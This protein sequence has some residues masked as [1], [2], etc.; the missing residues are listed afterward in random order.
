VR[1]DGSVKV[2][3]ELNDTGYPGC[4]YNLIFDTSLD[5]LTGTYF[6]AQM[7]ETWPVVFVRQQE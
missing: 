2:G 7:R 3:V 6:Q 1:E 5:Q 4:L